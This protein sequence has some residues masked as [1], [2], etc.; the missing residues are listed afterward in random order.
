M[1]RLSLHDTFLGNNWWSLA[2]GFKVNG[3]INFAAWTDQS[4]QEKK[5]EEIK[6]AN[7]DPAFENS[8]PTMTTDQLAS[9]FK[10]KLPPGSILRS[11][12]LNM[13]TEFGI[14]WL[15]LLKYRHEQQN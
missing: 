7:I 4:G 11:K 1:K 14:D 9:F 8:E 5:S 2:D 15:K 6:G 3:Q 12:G 10:Y 13:K